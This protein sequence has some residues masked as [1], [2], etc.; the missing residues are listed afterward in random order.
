MQRLRRLAPLVGVPLLLSAATVPAHAATPGGQQAQ[1]AVAI[2]LITG[3]RVDVTPRPGGPALVTFA[4]GP[5]SRSDAAVTTYSA[6]HTYVVPSAASADVATGRLDRT[7]FDVTTLIAEQRDDAHSKTVPLIIRYAGTPPAALTRAKAAKAPGATATRVLS[8]IGAKAAAIGKTRTTD[9]WRSITP[10]KGER[11]ASTIQ[12]VSLD[13]KVHIALDQSVP[14]I[15]AP[16]AWQRGLTGKGVKVAVLDTGIDPNHPDFAGRIA[17]SQNFTT[18]DDAVDHIGHGTHVASITAGDGAASGGKYKGVAPEAT[19]LNGKVLDDF[20]NGDDS[21]VIAGM[22]WAVAQGASVI[23]LSLGGNDPSDGTDDLSQ[24]VNQLSRSTG[25][26]IVIAAGNCPA[27][28][29]STVTSPAAADDALAVGNMLR[30][31]EMNPGSCRGPRLGDGALKPEISAPGTGIVAARAAGTDLGQ[32]VDD[33]YTTLSGTSMATP[34]VS[35]TAALVVQAHPTWKAAQLKA[36]LIST[37]DPQPGSRVDEQG[38][39]RVDADQATDN[40]TT[41]DTG[42]LEL[43]MLPWPHPANDPV[44][45]ELTY[46][47]PGTTPVALKLSASIDPAA[48]TPKLST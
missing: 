4:P 29:P 35:G 45:R 8:S 15:G 38:A 10:G 48:A 2:T 19:L 37:A 41:V 36:R 21:G 16:A 43:G 27:P 25:V 3:D 30:T 24:A 5:D 40:S 46:T 44:T 6:G 22:E 32:P 13:R 1:T 7:L 20:G 11:V 28:H 26:L 9:F 34:H 18:A 39:G 47:N 33:N 31:G 42:E 23:N 17:A 12:R 14:Q